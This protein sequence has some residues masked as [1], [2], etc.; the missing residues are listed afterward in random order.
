MAYE[1]IYLDE[2]T[3]TQL[4]HYIEDELLNHYAE[5]QLHIED[6]LRWQKD[7][8]A[9]PTKEKATFPFTGAATIVIPLEAI[10]VE[11]T[12]ARVMTTF[13]GFEQFVSAKAISPDWDPVAKPFERFID[14]ELLVLE[15]VKLVTKSM[16]EL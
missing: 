6:L 3:E 4:A 13:F 2:E 11:A 8:W 12:H 15:L 16:L 7:Y 14:R 10:A 9:K 1:E 5:R